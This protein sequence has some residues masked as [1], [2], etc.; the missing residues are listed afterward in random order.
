MT[1][2][3]LEPEDIFMKMEGGHFDYMSKIGSKS[4]ND[5]HLSYFLSS[6]V[7][8]QDSK[9]R[10]SN[11]TFTFSSYRNYGVVP[12][13]Y[14]LLKRK[15]TLGDRIN[16]NHIQL[17]GLNNKSYEVWMDNPTEFLITRAF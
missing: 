16:E 12:N 4:F 13:A 2:T 11:L 14:R 7:N 8:L 6:R 9:I 5:N 15:F 1:L 3:I 17:V 10:D